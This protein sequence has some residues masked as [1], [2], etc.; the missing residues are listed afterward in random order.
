MPERPPGLDLGSGFLV[1]VPILNAAVGP[2]SVVAMA[3]SAPSPYAMG[4]VIRFN[5]RHAEPLLADGTISDRAARH[6]RLANLALVLAYAIS[7]C[8]YIHIL[9]AFLLGGLG[10]NTPFRE[11]LVCVIIIAAIGVMGRLRGLDMLLVMERW[12]L[13]ITGLLDS[14]TAGGLCS[15]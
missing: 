11:N 15:V 13:Q 6:E 2:Y 4:S 3:A 5:I 1:I 14:G 12:A 7:V 9:A 8:L 10:I